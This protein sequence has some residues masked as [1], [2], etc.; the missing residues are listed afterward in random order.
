MLVPVVVGVAY[1]W[2]TVPDRTASRLLTALRAGDLTTANKMLNRQGT[3][4]NHPDG[5]IQFDSELGSFV[6][7]GLEDVKQRFTTATLYK[8][9]FSDVLC[10][11]RRIDLPSSVFAFEFKGRQILVEFW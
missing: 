10:R 2:L 6:F 1:W 11:Q 9:G 7:S 5:T 8:P 4:T 3:F